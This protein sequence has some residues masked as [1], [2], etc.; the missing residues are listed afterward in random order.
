MFQSG[1]TVVVNPGSDFEIH[2]T[3]RLALPDQLFRRYP[4]EVAV[5]IVGTPVES[6]PMVP[7]IKRCLFF[8]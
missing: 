2:F 1:R 3:L 4:D 8:G 6:V 5:P 7:K